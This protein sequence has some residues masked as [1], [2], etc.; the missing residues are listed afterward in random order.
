MELRHLKYFVI[1]AEELNFS[2]A[3]V[4]LYLSQPTLSR[5]IKN[6]EDELGVVLFL[7][8]SDGLTLTQAF[9]FLHTLK[10]FYSFNV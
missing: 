10:E 4:R 5:Q 6:L 8:Q 3:A 1:V 2:R 7:R 9:F